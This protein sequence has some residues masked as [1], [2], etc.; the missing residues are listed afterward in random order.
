MLRKPVEVG[1]KVQNSRK[2]WAQK[3]IQSYPFEIQQGPGD[4]A[5][6]EIKDLIHNGV[7]VIFA[8]SHPTEGDPLRVFGAAVA[9][10]SELLKREWQAP[11]AWHHYNSVVR[12]IAHRVGLTLSP[13]ITESTVQKKKNKGKRQGYGLLD[14][15][16]DMVKVAS[17][18]GAIFIAP[19]GTRHETITV[20]QGAIHVISKTL[21]G[22]NDNAVIIPVGIDVPTDEKGH[23]NPGRNKGKIYGITFGHPVPLSQVRSRA[24]KEGTVDKVFYT[25]LTHVVSSK[26]GGDRRSV[27]KA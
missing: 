1:D 5:V 13:I 10:F 27:Q 15:K 24:Q 14:H 8:F 16:K 19:E 23:V 22:H 17:E 20:P 7:P 18:G 4:T 2:W 25:M 21:H 26:H 12:F 3:L 9:T 11:I 6:A